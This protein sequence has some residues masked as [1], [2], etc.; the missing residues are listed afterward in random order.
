MEVVKTEFGLSIRSERKNGDNRPV[1]KSYDCAKLNG[2][3][4]CHARANIRIARHPNPAVSG[5]VWYIYT[6]ADNPDCA[7]DHS[8]EVVNR[9]LAR[10]IR[11]IEACFAGRDIVYDSYFRD[12]NVRPFDSSHC[13]TVC[14]FV[15]L[16][17]G[18]RIYCGAAGDEP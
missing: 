16:D 17:F 12:I 15:Y 3:P 7:H 5:T 18:F 14:L 11:G 4:N 13:A 8:D 1:Y 6:P 9:G 2:Y 10:Q